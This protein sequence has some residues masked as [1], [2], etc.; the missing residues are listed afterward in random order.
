M[1]KRSPEDIRLKN[2]IADR[3]KQ[4]REKTGLS[5]ADFAKNHH[6]DRQHI[7]NWESKTNERG[8]TIYTIKKF[9]DMIDISL[10]DFFDDQMFM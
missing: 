6:L 4:L 8:V 10:R 1:A 2:A 5:Q 3:I 9:C 7:N